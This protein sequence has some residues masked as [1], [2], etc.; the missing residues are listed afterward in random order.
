MVGRDKDAAAKDAAE[1]A[2]SLGLLAADGNSKAQAY[3]GAEK[4]RLR[5]GENQVKQAFAFNYARAAVDDG[6]MQD[7]VRNF[8]GLLRFDRF[9][10]DFTLFLST[11]GRN[12]KFQ[13][14]DFRL[15]VD[16]GAAYYFINQKEQLLW[17]EFGYDLTTDFRNQEAV[18]A[19]RA[20]AIADG[21][22]PQKIKETRTLHSARLFFGYDHAL[23][24]TSKLTL[25]LEYLQGIASNESQ[26]ANAYRVNFDAALTA[27]VFKALSMAT[28]YSLRIDSAAEQVGKKKTDQILAASLVYTFL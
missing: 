13:G 23:S 9:L 25:G 22:D 8:Q 15:Q 16:P 20:T 26:T 12:D 28:S 19:A 24:D 5:R 18:D 7:T 2:L 4:Y 27:K 17:T 14:L 10:G 6:P 11:Q 3:T 21:K 1:L